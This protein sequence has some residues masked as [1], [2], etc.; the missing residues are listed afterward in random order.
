MSRGS[1]VLG[2][3]LDRYRRNRHYQRSSTFE[4]QRHQPTRTIPGVAIYEPRFQFS[5]YSE[6]LVVAKTLSGHLRSLFHGYSGTV[7]GVKI[8]DARFYG[9][10]EFSDPDRN[11]HHVPVE[12][13]FIHQ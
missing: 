4:F 9:E 10:Q 11:E 6:D 7:S 1:L 2:S 13:L 5:I 3:L 8:A 12:F